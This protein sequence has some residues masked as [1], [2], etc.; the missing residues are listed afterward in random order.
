M[1]GEGNLRDNKQGLV[2]LFDCV[3]QDVFV[4]LCFSAASDPPEEFYFLRSFCG[5]EGLCLVLRE[6]QE[7]WI[8][9]QGWFFGNNMGFL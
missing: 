7:C 3:E 8:G 1:V 4:D 5:R 2:A 6:W 9:W